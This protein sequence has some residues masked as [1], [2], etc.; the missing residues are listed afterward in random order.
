MRLPVQRD[1]A[2]PSPTRPVATTGISGPAPA[3]AGISAP[4]LA[5][6]DPTPGPTAGL[7]RLNA[8]DTATAEALLLPCCGSRRWA[9]RVAEH[10]PYGDLGA[11]LAA[12]DEA[13]YDLTPAD[14]AEALAA[15]PRDA[16]SLR[17]GADAEGAART[18]LHAALTAYEECFGHGFVL[19]LDPRRPEEWLDLTLTALR[20]RLSGDPETER[21]DSAEQLRRLTRARL[22]H[23]AGGTAPGTGTDAVVNTGMNTGA[24]RESETA[25]P[26]GVGAGPGAPAHA[27]RRVDEP[28]RVPN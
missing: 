22:E 14:L 12:G 18:A 20:T 15:E 16:A 10:R 23:L 27:P 8:A 4:P 5:D 19:H 1:A 26:G 25:V 6:T 28:G 9:R 17:V 24:D 11:L 2:P 7:R 13:S 3:S 21:E